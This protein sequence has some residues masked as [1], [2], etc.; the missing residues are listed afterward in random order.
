[1]NDLLQ[2]AVKAHGGLARWKQLKAIHVASSITGAIWFL[3]GQGDCLKN[4]A[5]IVDTTKECLVTDFPGQDKRSIFEPEP[6]CDAKERRNSPRSARRSRG[7]LRRTTTRD[8]V[9][10]HPRRLLSRRSP[11]DLPEHTFS[12]H[13]RRFRDRGDRINRS[14]GRNLEKIEVENKPLVLVRTAFSI[15]TT[16]QSISWAARPALTTLPNI[17]LLMASSFQRNVASI[18]ARMITVL[19]WNP[20]W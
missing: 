17:E 12:I 8:A 3:K 14:G 2:K 16:T 13:A 10:R 5:M 4:I 15:G 9:E 19:S 1:M 6:H 18:P 20:C 11:V 7:L